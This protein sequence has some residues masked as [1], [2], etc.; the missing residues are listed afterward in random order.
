MSDE[1]LLK[2]ILKMDHKQRE[3]L[4]KYV[5]F[6]VYPDQEDIDVFEIKKNV[7]SKYSETISAL[8]AKAEVYL[9]DLPKQVCGLIEMVFRILTTSAVE[10]K[11]SDEIA[12]CA[13]SLEYELF[14]LNTLNALLIECYIKE[15]KRYRKLFK[16]FKHKGV[17]LENGTSFMKEINVQLKSACAMFKIGKKKYKR[18]YSLNFLEYMVMLGKFSKIEN[19]FSWMERFIPYRL[20]VEIGIGAEISELDQ[21]FQKVQ[22]IV[23]ICENNYSTIINN[24]YD[25]S[26]IKRFLLHLPS[27]ISAG[28]TILA[29]IIIFKKW[30]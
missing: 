11:K 21:C 27:I 20:D 15:I 10:D 7:Y 16:K 12:L 26:F 6:E 13:A 18:M 19:K 2:Q 30:F 28:L 8:V 24:G 9:H 5:E 3:A 14:L 22:G 17:I 23:D 29:A 1:E 4:E 25:S